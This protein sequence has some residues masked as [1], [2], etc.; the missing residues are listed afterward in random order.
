MENL[1]LYS[2][3]VREVYDLGKQYLLMKAT[4]R[5]S[6]F[7]KNIGII[8]GKG[9][10]LNKMSEFWFHQTKDIIDNH[11][12]STN[13]DVALVKKC[14][15][16]KIE[17]VVRGYITGNTSTS[18]WTHYNNGARTYCDIIFPHG[19][20]RDQQLP[21]PVIT[22][23]T[24]GVVDKPISRADIIAENYMTEEECDYIFSKAMQLFK[25][26]QDVADEAGLILVDTK[27][28]FGKDENGKILLIDE[29]HTCDSSRYWIKSSYKERFSNGESPEKLDKD[30]VRDWVKANCDPYNDEIP[31]VPEEI[32]NKALNAYQSFYDKISNISISQPNNL[33]LIV[34]GS[35]KDEGHIC[36][37]KTALDKLGI[38]SKSFVS[39]AHKNT[40]AVMRLIDEYD[41]DDRN[42]VWVTIA[43]RS[44]ALS[45]VVA[46]NSRQPVIACP[47]FKDQVDM[48]VNINSTLQC[49][50]NVPV[51]T[52]LEPGN[53]ALCIK[54]MFAFAR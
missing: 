26:G 24:K 36:K 50:S 3:K 7:D 31:E 10:L 39:S 28:E 35:I 1:L 15:P 2:G 11:L 13:E 47:P 17:V 12:I 40:H 51:M 42:I 52:I 9:L 23:T 20:V 45:G 41:I 43:G 29:V 48:M 25:F 27:Y 38:A 46:S 16:F 30:C 44:N 37:V 54:K 6:C 8:P 49:P 21:E 18:L 53:V 33:V 14:T 22:P 5:I 4:D 34:A 32:I 19:L